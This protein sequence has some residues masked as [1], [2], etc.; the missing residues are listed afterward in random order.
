MKNVRNLSKMSKGGIK[1]LKKG[2]KAFFSRKIEEN[3]RF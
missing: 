3:A 1:R 2:K